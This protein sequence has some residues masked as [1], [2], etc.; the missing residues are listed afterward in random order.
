MTEDEPDYITVTFKLLN[1]NYEL[2]YSAAVF[3]GEGLQTVLN[4]ACGLY[5]A[6]HRIEP[7]TVVE[8]TDNNGQLRKV[9]LLPIVARPRWAR[10]LK[11][12]GLD[13]SVTLTA[14]EAKR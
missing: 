13:V 6:L 7:G 5:E 4:R 9:V 12:F 1:Q 3:Q 14:A 2:L 8:W 10:W 11:W